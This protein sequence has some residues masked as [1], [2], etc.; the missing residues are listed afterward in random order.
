[1]AK[2]ATKQTTEVNQPDTV[3]QPQ[4]DTST[5]IVPES[6]NLADLALLL[7]IVDLA[8]QRGAFRGAELSQVGNVFD[9]LNAFLS[10]IQA[11]Q[12]AGSTEPTEDQ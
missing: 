12:Q 7:Q 6:I 8:T 5:N 4:T 9:K 3:N 10:Y 2:T 11:Q 1:M